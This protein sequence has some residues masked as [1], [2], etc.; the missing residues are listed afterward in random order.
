MFVGVG[1]RGSTI[2]VEIILLLVVAVKFISYLREGEQRV[3]QLLLERELSLL[4]TIGSRSIC[5][6][7]RE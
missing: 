5:Q 2:E 3:H 4:F 6:L 1:T 7:G